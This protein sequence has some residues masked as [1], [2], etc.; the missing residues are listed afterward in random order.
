MV[1]AWGSPEFVEMRRQAGW[2]LAA[3]LSRRCITACAQS[4]AAATGSGAGSAQAVVRSTAASGSQVY[5]SSRAVDEYLL[6][7]Y[8][9][10]KDVMPYSFGPSDALDFPMRLADLCKSSNSGRRGR[11]ALDIGCSVGGSAFELSRHFDQVVGVDF[12]QHFIDAANDLKANGTRKFEMM[13]QGQIFVTREAKVSADVD[14]SR[15]QFKQGDA[16]NLDPSLG[17][18]DVILASNLLCRLPSPRK[19]IERVP[20]FLSPGGRLVLVSPYSWLQE[21]TADVGEWF[22]AQLDANGQ[23][24]DSFVALKDFIGSKKLPLKLLSEQDTSFL[25]R[26]HERKFQYGVS[27]VTIWERL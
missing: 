16:C 18:F 4:C 25:I 23:P 9:N 10:A 26:E 21:Y 6:F 1:A 14:R 24:I 27:H 12:S 19:F 5:E 20:D 13:K 17:Q 15:V 22:G 3:G 2:L 8:G 7:H 11:R